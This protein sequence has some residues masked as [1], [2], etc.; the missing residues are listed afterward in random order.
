MNRLSN[1]SKKPCMRTP[2]SYNEVSEVLIER[3]QNALVSVC[4][5]E[6]RFVPRIAGPIGDCFDIVTVLT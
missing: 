6:N 1:E 3:Y 5:R 4:V 2:I